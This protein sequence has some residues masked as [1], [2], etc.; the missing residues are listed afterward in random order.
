M[1][2]DHR[3]IPYE[4]IGHERAS[5][6]A[7]TVTFSKTDQQGRGRILEHYVDVE[8]PTHCIVQR[9]EAYIQLTRDYYGALDSH[10]LFDIP[11]FPR[12]TTE[13]IQ[14]A[15]Q[16]TCHAVGL[17]WDKCSAHSLRYGG[18]TT[19]AAAGFP[20]FVIAFYGGWSPDSTVMRRYMKPSNS[21]VKQVSHHMTR[22]QNAM[23]VQATVN[24][25]LAFRVPSNPDGPFLVPQG[26]PRRP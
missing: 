10:L 21:V 25:I 23:A 17:P 16:A 14:Y 6:L 13:V 11:G 15:M 12:L 9:M 2:K 3:V 19:L 24:Q 20:D 22:A 4:R 26:R 7:I 5:W 18:A 8:N 1:D